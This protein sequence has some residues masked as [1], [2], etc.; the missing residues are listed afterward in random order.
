MKKILLNMLPLGIG[1]VL[2]TSLAMPAF[3]QIIGEVGP[4]ANEY[5]TDAFECVKEQWGPGSQ[6]ANPCNAAKNGD[7][8]GDSV[9]DDYDF[10]CC[11]SPPNGGCCQYKCTAYR[12]QNTCGHNSID[13]EVS[14]SGEWSWPYGI[15]EYW[16]VTCL[17]HGRLDYV[18]RHSMT[19][20]PN[21]TC[22]AD[23]GVGL[24]VGPTE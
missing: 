14:P 15:G 20:F 5:S 11:M 22:N 24:C 18:K 12:C 9:P 19:Y 13:P 7:N 16:R 17:S 23:P 10:N 21:G 2:A 6:S 3:S 8:C 4:C 1:V